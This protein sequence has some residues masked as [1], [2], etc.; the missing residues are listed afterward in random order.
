MIRWLHVIGI[1][2]SLLLIIGC[3]SQSVPLRETQ[4]ID[5]LA[6]T[7]ET[8]ERPQMNTA[9][10]FIVVLQDDQGNPVSDANVYLDLDMP[11]MPMGI[12]RPVA[13]PE[14]SGRYW[15]RTAYTMEGLWEITVVVEHAETTYRATFRRD[16]LK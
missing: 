6:I 5:G 9:V 8:L 4:V 7:L 2:S 15:A 16:V 10:D 11:A 12:T 13:V 1:L 3:D 14:G